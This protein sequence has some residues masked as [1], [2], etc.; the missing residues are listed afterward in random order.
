MDVFTDEKGHFLSCCRIRGTLCFTPTPQPALPHCNGKSEP[1]WSAGVAAARCGSAGPGRRAWGRGRARVRSGTFGESRPAP[2]SRG[3]PAAQARHT[4][5][6]GGVCRLAGAA[7]T[8]RAASPRPRREWRAAGGP[9]PA[10]PPG[11]PSRPRAPRPRSSAPSSVR[12]ARSARLLLWPLPGSFAAGWE[13]RGRRARVS[14]AGQAVGAVAAVGPWAAAWDES[15]GAPASV[16]RSE[17]AEDR[18]PSVTDGWPPVV[19]GDRG[20]G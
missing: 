9:A 16:Y 2:P 15:P 7:T 3:L 10:P 8:R 14:T 1:G 19:V 13:A 6:G 4:V 11:A 20:S 18:T 12:P 5:I 17:P